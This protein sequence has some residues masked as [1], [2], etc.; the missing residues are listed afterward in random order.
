MKEGQYIIAIGASAGGMSQINTFFDYTPLDS[1]SYIIIQ[2]LSA[3]YKSM[4]S[5]L[6]EKH[7]KLHVV[8]AEDGMAVEMN[9]VYLIPSKN[10][11]TIKDGR[12]VLTNKQKGVNLTIDTFFNSLAEQIG[13]KSIGVILSGTGRDG[14]EG[15]RAIKQAGGLV[16]VC[17]PESA[18]YD[19]MPLSAI[20]TGNADH[21]V[22]PEQMPMLI[23]R[24]V[25]GKMSAAEMNI[26]ETDEEVMKN[27]TGL[28]KD[29][30]PE[31]F[32]G[33]KKS[34]IIRR[35]K[36]RAALLNFNDL[37]S[38][39]DL[40]KKDTAE[41]Q[42]L[43][44]DFLISVTSFFR[45]KAAFGIVEQQII[46]EMIRSKHN[47]D[48]KV[49][50]AGCATGEEAYSLAILI[51]EQLQA[52][53]K[54]NNIKIFA[55]DIDDEA[56]QFAGKGYYPDS[57]EKDV[58]PERLERYFIRDNK[59]Y[60][61]K[62]SIREMLIFAHH[63]LVKNPPYC[64]MDFISCRNLLIYMNP[65][66]QRKILNMLHFGMKYGGYLFLG[67]SENV[68][69]FIT[70]L[71]EVS[72]KW[73]LYKNIEAKRIISFENFTSPVFTEGKI[74]AIT[75]KK[76]DGAEHK[77]IPHEISV[78]MDLLVELGYAGLLIDANDQV[79][80]VLGDST[81]FLSQKMFVHHL[82][83]LLSKHLQIAFV[84]A[85]I[86]A[87]TNNKLIVVKGI[88]VAG[89]DSSVTLSVRPL[90]TNGKGIKTRLVLFSE[91][92]CNSNTLVFDE[93]FFKDK[94][95]VNLEEELA[96]TREKLASAHELLDASNENMQ[97]FNEELLSANEEMQS[98]NEEMQSVNEE[99]HTINTEYQS[100]IRE[101]SDLN[102][103]LNNYFRSNVNGQI[104]VNKDLLLMKFSPGAEV[105]I[106]LLE[107]DIG[108]P[109]SNISTNIRFE[110]I[111]EDI[112]DVLANGCVV[113]R[114]LQAINGKWFQV[115]TMPYL[116]KGNNDTDGA[117]VTFNDVSE[118]KKI[119]QELSHSNMI[120][121]AINTDLD[122]FV[123][124]SSHDLLSPMNNIEQIIYFIKEREGTLDNE[125]K[126]YVNMLS[127]AV[128]KFRIVIKEMAAIGRMESEMFN[129][130]TVGIDEI[131]GEVLESIQWRISSDHANIQTILDVKE[132]H[133]SRKNCRSMVYNL[134]NNALKFKSPVR[135][136]EIIITTK[137]LP[138]Y[139]LLSVKDN[140]IGISKSKINSI[141]K[142][143]R[144]L[145]EGVEGQGL[146]LFLINKIIDAS[147]GK[148]EV[149]SEVGVG[150]EFKLYIKK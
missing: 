142:M 102:D 64:N 121:K 100:K 26:D 149:E 135:H 61:I 103:D 37:E 101:L 54:K 128:S 60:K 105:H 91:E 16:F 150:T 8:E 23:K 96:S 138:D 116:R 134:I 31:D 10:L 5:S 63:D 80:N 11:M 97:S 17:T 125:T 75:Q 83:D 34:T 29:K 39:Q 124:T 104:F 46:P 51:S 59:G 76:S 18:E 73:K 133:F 35:I 15:I 122:N 27:I 49:W 98:T 148:I 92:D 68:S 30:L 131:I 48:I 53:G 108:R 40:L 136:P 70:H 66:L 45:D 6:L 42:I 99:L 111:E 141:F 110:N 71:E 74:N 95:A 1:V 94:Y 143:Y 120:L 84:T 65:T 62:S 119:Q 82:P 58:S 69:D 2:H 44:K 123:F 109:L 88:K 89:F 13:N 145:N 25:D 52:S 38:Y 78:E 12:L 36:R 117:I 20:A 144:Q 57:I 87:D 112:R 86:E 24:Y 9:N 107:I 114:E 132:I 79:L 77:N 56:L 127:S 115:M 130:E 90:S 7:S 4:M 140:G 146:G 43:V 19:Q 106:N 41:L 21:I 22:A 32:S 81:R 14:T 118:L 55:T 85:A 147:G 113:T 67:P 93:H 137:E 50:V 139:I 72:K 129:M 33:Y 126:G 3:D 47:D 28:I